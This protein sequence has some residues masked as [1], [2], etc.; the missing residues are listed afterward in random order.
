[1]SKTLKIRLEIVVKDERHCSNDCPGMALDAKRC[2]YYDALLVWDEKR[3]THGNFR[4]TE[5]KMDQL[6]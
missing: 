5:C 4:L 1:M 6:P 2:R 3:N